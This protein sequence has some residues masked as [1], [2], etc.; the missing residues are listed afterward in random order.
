MAMTGEPAIL[1][2]RSPAARFAAPIAW[3]RQNPGLRDARRFWA[4]QRALAP[5]FDKIAHDGLLARKGGAYD[6]H[7]GSG[8]SNWCRSQHFR[9]TPHEPT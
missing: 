5:D 6:V 9:F 1:A 8:A 2:S 7:C 4:R 3:A